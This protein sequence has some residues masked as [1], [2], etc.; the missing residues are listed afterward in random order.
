MDSDVVICGGG[1]AGLAAGHALV[2]AG[3]GV[4][5]L[6]GQARVGGLAVNFKQSLGRLGAWGRY[7][8]VFAN[9]TQL[10][11]KGSR[12][13][14]FSSFIKRSANWGVNF[15]YKRFDL[16][17]RWNHRGLRRGSLAPAFGPD[18]YDYFGATTMLDL[19]MD[20]RF[21]KQLAFFVS[22]RNVFN[23]KRLQYT[24]G[25]QTPEYAKRNFIREYGTQYTAGIKGTF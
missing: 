11:L 19:N 21:R 16:M 18:A 10:Q 14:D 3:R 15:G 17:A 6:E 23:V 7:F 13:T 5:V 22:A 20:Y 2:R 8:S 12:E 24:Y 9:G 1:L 25:S 4:V